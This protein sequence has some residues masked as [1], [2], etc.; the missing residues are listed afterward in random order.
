MAASRTILGAAL[1]VA[2]SLAL[3]GCGTTADTAAIVDGKVITHEDVR[4]ATEQINAQF[5]PQTP[6]TAQSTLTSLILAP[7][8]IAA[9]EKKGRP[10]SV[11]SARSRLRDIADPADATIELVRASDAAGGLT[12]EDEASVLAAI[13]KQDV[14]VNPRYGAF[15][16]TKPGL[17]ESV[18]AWI[19]TAK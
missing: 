15:D 5:K 19:S 16:A 6:L 11:G 7:A 18:P 12:A 9:A 4:L 13:R 1:V 8:L 17:V 2:S 10:Q 3:A 14:T